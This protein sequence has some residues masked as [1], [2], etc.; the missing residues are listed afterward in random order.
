MPH[1]RLIKRIIIKKQL[2]QIILRDRPLIIYLIRFC[3]Q[4][5]VVFQWLVRQ[6]L[7]TTIDNES[8]WVVARDHSDIHPGE[9]GEE[10]SGPGVGGEIEVLGGVVEGYRG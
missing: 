4:I 6:C 8:V 10:E 3:I 2:H 1:H 5:E 7:H 9:F